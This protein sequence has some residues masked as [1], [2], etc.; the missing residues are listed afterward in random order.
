MPLLDH[1][2]ASPVL[3]AA[4]L[5]LAGV[6]LLY[7]VLCP[8][9]REAEP[10][11]HV[12]DTDGTTLTDKIA[13]PELTDG[14]LPPT[15][16][17]LA[18]DLPLERTSECLICLEPMRRTA[19]GSC[20]HH[21]CAVCLLECCRLTPRCPRCQTQIKE[22]W[23][24]A[25]YDAVLRSAQSS[26]AAGKVG[27]WSRSATNESGT[28]SGPV[29]A[30]LASYLRVLRLPHKKRFVGQV[31]GAGITLKTCIGRPGVV[32]ADLDVRDMGYL[33]GLRVGD[34]IVSMNGA[35]CRNHRQSIALI[36]RLSRTATPSEDAQITC[37]IIP[38]VG[39]NAPVQVPAEPWEADD[40]EPDR[41]GEAGALH[42]MEHEQDETTA[43]C[44]IL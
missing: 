1:G 29:D 10:E 16:L 2:A 35:A 34:V 18:D 40:D 32:I 39:L 38:H 41:R 13:E 43:E 5:G 36:N 33:C 26:A 11:E 15:R 14:R 28:D 3:L 7:L 24:D 31:S 42:I 25:E 30:R 27:W 8:L 37:L 9:Q 20:P 4:L 12:H 22:V 21:F 23:L 17:M 6:L 19:I 44:T